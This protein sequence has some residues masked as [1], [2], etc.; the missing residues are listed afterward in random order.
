MRHIQSSTLSFLK[1]LNLHNNR[2]WFDEHKEQYLE[3]KKNV[4]DFIGALIHGIV[5]FDKSVQ[6]VEPS[7]CMFRIYRDVRFAKNKSP[8]KPYFRLG[9]MEGGKS[10]CQQPG[11]FMHIEPGG[12]T[13]I[14]GGAHKAEAEWLGRIRHNIAE[15]STEL[16]K[17][18]DN[19]QFK[20]YFGSMEGEQLKSA[21]KG[22]PKD[23]PAIDLLKYK[24]FMA[25]HSVPDKQVLGTDFVSYALKAYRAL[26]DFNRFL[27]C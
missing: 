14:V 18:L 11:Y 1:N 8:Y 17:I 27:S 23:H 26:Y 2:E 21:P 25:V 3:A 4:E 22:Y 10:N 12:N 19:K 6:H 5:A 20:E 13:R 15:H 16:R 9:I 7:E 24:D